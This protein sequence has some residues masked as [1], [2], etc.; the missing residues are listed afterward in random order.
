MKS[1]SSKSS[2]VI[3]ATFRYSNGWLI[4]TMLH[5]VTLFCESTGIQYF[6][7]KF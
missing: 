1:V 2:V 6:D 7:A 4:R 5:P 3:D